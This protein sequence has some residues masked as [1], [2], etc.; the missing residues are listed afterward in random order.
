MTLLEVSLHEA[1]AEAAR[2]RGGG[3][4]H[5]D[6]MLKM[7]QTASAEVRFPPLP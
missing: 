6:A 4:E 5:K 3:K 7:A 2:E 1:R